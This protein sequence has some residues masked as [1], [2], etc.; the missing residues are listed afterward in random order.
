MPGRGWCL[1]AVVGLVAC[2]AR[3]APRVTVGALADG[4]AAFLAAHPRG[5]RPIRVDEVARTPGASYHLV[6]AAESESPHRHVTHDLTVVVLRGRGR[7]TLG[8]ATI[9]MGAG[10]A[11][12]VP[13]NVVHWFAPAGG[14]DAV[15][16]AVFTPPLDAPDNVPAGAR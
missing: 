6:Q 4:L 10:D 16:L 11:V 5:E 9:P 15:A 8:E 7:L 1:V 14:A 3:P 13:R 2:A 12:L